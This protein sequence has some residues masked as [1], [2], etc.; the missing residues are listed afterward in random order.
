M[1]TFPA[2]RMEALEERRLMTVTRYRDIVYVEGTSRADTIR[3]EARPH[4]ANVDD[5][6]DVN[7]TAAGTL[8]D[9]VNFRTAD[10]SR[11]VVRANPL[12]DRLRADS[13]LPV[14]VGFVSDQATGATLAGDVLVVQGGRRSDVIR[15]Y[16]N[17]VQGTDIAVVV[18]GQAAQY[19]SDAARA[20]LIF[21]NRRDD[22]IAIGKVNLPNLVFG[23]DGND[24]IAGS[25]EDDYFSGDLGNDTLLGGAGDDQLLGADE[26]DYIDGGDGNDYIAA[27]GPATVLGGNGD[28]GIL[29]NTGNAVRFKGG[30]GQDRMG[31][32]ISRNDVLQLF[33]DFDSAED[34]YTQLH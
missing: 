17:R 3:I 30:P 6:F 1:N 18:N 11:I 4:Q 12:K 9:N 33:L 25:G 32:A 26:A 27:E 5:S 15:V 16:R 28:D 23:G 8:V 14:A 20:L 10:V 19:S 22:D 24:S 31:A 2:P 7:I 21:G 13:T 34:S 29:V